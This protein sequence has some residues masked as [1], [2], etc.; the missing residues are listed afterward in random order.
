DFFAIFEAKTDDKRNFCQILGVKRVKSDLRYFKI[1][2]DSRSKV[3]KLIREFDYSDRAL[4]RD[5]SSINFKIL[6]HTSEE[7][8]TV[9]LRK[10]RI[11]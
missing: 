2:A 7:Y 10:R 11:Y 8:L 5:C 3:I 4:K 9:I 6:L 1:K